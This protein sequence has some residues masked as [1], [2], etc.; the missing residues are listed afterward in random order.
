MSRLIDSE[1]QEEIR[2]MLAHMKSSVRLVLF[3]GKNCES[4]RLQRDLLEELASLSSMITLDPR[5]LE[6]DSE[7]A[8]TLKVDKVPAT[9]VMGGGT[10]GLDSMV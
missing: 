1:A 6:K 2:A 8:R 7:M 9:L 4:C 10:T 5:E 3:Q